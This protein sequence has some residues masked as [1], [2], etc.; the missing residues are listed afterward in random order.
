MNLQRPRKFIVLV[1]VTLFMISPFLIT[2]TTSQTPPTDLSSMSIALYYGSSTSTNSRTSMQF[3][4]SWMNA[5]VDVLYASDISDGDLSDYDMIAVPGGWAGTYNVDL[6]GTGITEIRN[7][8]RDGGAFFGVCAGAY[9]GCDKLLWEGGVL[10]YPL[11]LFEGFGIGPVEEIA[12]WPNRAMTE[13]II[14][15]T[16]P[17]IDLSGEPV[18]HTVMYFGGPWFDIAGKEG[19]HSLATYAANNES[20]MIAFEYEDGRVFL[21]GPHPEA[22]E[23]SD[24]DNVVGWDNAFDD[25]GS[26]WDMMLKVSLW[27]L[28]NSGSE[29]TSPT[30]NSGSERTSPTSTNPEEPFNLNPIVI[31]GGI[32]FGTIIIALVLIK[33]P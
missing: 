21:S 3:M 31:I 5:S 33:R 16:S 18:N 1:I 13:I 7:F 26:E 12:A 23:D 6:A 9:F 32:S 29:T 30:N 19:I 11:N 2:T 24:R 27:L 10:E 20:A 28:E 17:L 25:F 4:F 8:V 15:Q 22:E 14:N